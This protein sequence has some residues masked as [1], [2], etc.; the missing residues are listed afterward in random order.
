MKKTRSNLIIHCLVLL[1]ASLSAR[2][3]NTFTAASGDWDDPANWLEGVVPGEGADVIINGNATLTN[4]TPQLASLVVNSNMSITFDRWDTLLSATTITVNGT[5]KHVQNSDT[6]SVDGWTPNARVNIACNDFTL[7]GTGRINV[8]GLGYLGGPRGALDGCGP[9]GGGFVAANN[10]GGGGFGGAGAG[11]YVTPGVYGQPYGAFQSPE[12]PGSGGAGG[13]YKPANTPPVSVLGCPGGGAVKIT[14]TGRVIV[15]GQILA[16]GL[17][18]VQTAGGGSGG[19]IFITCKTFVSTNGTLNASGGAGSAWGGDAGGGGRIS[20]VYDTVEQ[21]AMP[22][23]ELTIAASAGKPGSSGVEADL[24][25]LFFSDSQFLT[26]ATGDIT[27]SGRWMASLNGTL[28][29]PS[30]SL[31]NCWLRFPENGFVLETQGNIAVTGTDIS[32]HKLEMTNGVLRAGGSIVLN[33][34]A[35]VLR[36]GES[37]GPLVQGGGL[38]LTNGAAL[39][40]ES[41]ITASPTNPGARVELTGDMVVASAG[42]WVYP[43]SHPT[44]GASVLFKM[45]RLFLPTAGAGFNANGRGFKG[46]EHKSVLPVER[47]HGFGPGLGGFISDGHRGGGGYGGNGGGATTVFGNSYGTTNL[48]VWAGSGGSGGDSAGGYGGGA[49]R[50]EANRT[51]S[52]SGSILANGNRASG[53]PGAGSGGSVFIICREFAGTSTAVLSANGGNGTS[54]GGGRGGGGRIAVWYDVAEE[55]QARLWAGEM[56]RGVL[57]S[58]TYDAYLGAATVANGTG[59]S[60]LTPDSAPGTIVFLTVPP[61]HNT[62]IVVR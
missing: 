36:A 39:Y 41:A 22:V 56:W 2:G 23:P 54:W 10:S 21:N 15:N 18:N 25:T 31:K 13:D 30:L 55:D 28:T 62:V 40:I 26:R 58:T 9:G 19:S 5:L 1:L 4:S 27:Y 12:L 14:A 16:S 8:D 42:S 11:R 49:V 6:N 20:I 7:N 48:P 47:R 32:V 61:P 53:Y 34:A 52:I 57:A 60:A 46:G 33:K 43:I 3:I 44:N 45:D 38:L 59:G 17:G 24:G 50:I 51:V 35:M 37:G 29:L